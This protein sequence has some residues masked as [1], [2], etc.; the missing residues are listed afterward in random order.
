[1]FIS[2]NGQIEF[3]KLTEYVSPKLYLKGDFIK[4]LNF[5]KST[6]FISKF[7]VDKTNNIWAYIIKFNEEIP[8]TQ[9]YLFLVQS[10]QVLDIND[11]SSFFKS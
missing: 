10:N 7:Q 9:T 5:T 8:L 3:G 1:M 11:W 6:V 4:N 2:Q